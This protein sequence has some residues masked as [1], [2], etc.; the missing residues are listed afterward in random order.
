[1]NKTR[2]RHDL[3]DYSWIFRDESTISCLLIKSY[4]TRKVFGTMNMRSTHAK[5]SFLGP[6]KLTIRFLTIQWSRIWR[7][8]PSNQVVKM[9]W[10]TSRAVPRPSD[11][12]T[13]EMVCHAQ[14]MGDCC[15]KLFSRN[16]IK[17]TERNIWNRMPWWNERYYTGVERS[18][19][20]SGLPSI[21]RKKYP[22]F[23][24]CGSHGLL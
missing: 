19:H 12:L 6:I 14:R 4:K 11:H 2:I 17:H 24:H 20:S 1:M 13:K 10:S 7:S 3:T 23:H 18:S 22:S 9:F 16:R 5:R 15:G 8:N 21:H